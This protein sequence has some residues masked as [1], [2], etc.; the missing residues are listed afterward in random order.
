MYS[1]AVSAKEWGIQTIIAG[2]R[3]ATYLLGMVASLTSLPVIGVP[4]RIPSLDGVDF[5]YS[6]VQR[7]RGIL[8][9]TVVINNAANAGS[10]APRILASI[11]SDLY[12]RLIKYPQCLNN[13]VLAKANAYFF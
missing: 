5:L 3:G 6:N 4:I 2:A 1:F 8:L 11:D 7:P 12:E 13:T 10:L 9:A